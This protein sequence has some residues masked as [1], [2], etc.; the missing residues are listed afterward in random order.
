MPATGGAAC[1]PDHGAHPSTPAAAR[2]DPPPWEKMFFSLE[3]GAD[4]VV[5][6]LMN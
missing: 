2:P 3:Q 4:L 1:A 5:D 6:G